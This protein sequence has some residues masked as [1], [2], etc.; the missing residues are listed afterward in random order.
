MNLVVAHFVDGKIIKGMT[1]NFLPAKDRFHLLPQG[2]SVQDK[3][4]EILVADLKALFFVRS[5]DG[6]PNHRDKTLQDGAV[7]TAGR[8]IRVVFKDGELLEGTTQGYQP[9]RPGF[10]IVPLDLESNNER[11]YVVSSSTQ[12]VTLI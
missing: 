12:A 1:N 5:L 9:G 3:P 10:F 7:G 11:C 4:A 8:K 6:N 2:S